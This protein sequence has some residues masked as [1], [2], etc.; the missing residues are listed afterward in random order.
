M[1][2]DDVQTP[3]PFPFRDAHKTLSMPIIISQAKAT[4]TP[5]NANTN[6]TISLPCGL[7]AP[8]VKMG[9]VLLFVSDAVGCAYPPFETDE[10]MVGLI[11]MDEAIDVVGAVWLVYESTE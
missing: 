10:D 1:L 8:P 9:V 4:M 5:P 2:Y 6:P 11:T 3:F 7:L